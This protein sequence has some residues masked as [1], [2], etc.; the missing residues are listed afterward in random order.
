MTVT[1]NLAPDAPALPRAAKAL[2]ATAETHGWDVE[3]T[4][5]GGID[6]QVTVVA[7]H[8]DGTQYARVWSREPRL[9]HG[10]APVYRLDGGWARASDDMTRTQ[11]PPSV[12]RI[13]ELIAQQP[14]NKDGSS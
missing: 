6:G 3:I 10:S 14:A 8:P 13:R 11:S 12:T 4:G 5:Y 1:R 7:T 2:L 9:E